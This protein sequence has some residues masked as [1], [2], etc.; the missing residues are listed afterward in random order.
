MWISIPKRHIVV[1]DRI[2]SS[3]SLEELDVVM[4]PFLYMVPYLLVEDRPIYLRPELV[5]VACTL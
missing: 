4:E 5:I 2:C 1:F 3:I